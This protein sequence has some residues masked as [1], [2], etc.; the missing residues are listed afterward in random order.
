MKDKEQRCAR[1]G[2]Y[3]SP[4]NVSVSITGDKK[5]C[6]CVSCAHLI[7]EF[8]LVFDEWNMKRDEFIR[9]LNEGAFGFDLNDKKARREFLEELREALNDARSGSMIRRE[10]SNGAS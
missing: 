7:T 9:L 10:D 5:Y 4:Q 6:F 1:C 8:I 3:I 2:I